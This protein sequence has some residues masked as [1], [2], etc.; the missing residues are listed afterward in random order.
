MNSLDRD[1]VN[2][3]ASSVDRL[4]S[5]RGGPPEEE[6]DTPAHGSDTPHLPMVVAQ[7]VPQVGKSP[8]YRENR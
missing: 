6:M 1:E 8:E 5:D 2:S 7:P 3:L 4:L